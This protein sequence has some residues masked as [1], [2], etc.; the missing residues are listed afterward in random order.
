[1]GQDPRNK[2]PSAIAAKFAMDENRL[3][4]YGNEKREKI[5]ELQ[6]KAWRIRLRE[7][8]RS[9]CQAIPRQNARDCWCALIPREG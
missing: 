9:E 6:R 1:M 2:D 5:G 4:G 3:R 8:A 7:C